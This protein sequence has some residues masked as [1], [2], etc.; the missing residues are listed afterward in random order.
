MNRPDIFVKTL[1]MSEQEIDLEKVKIK[2][3]WWKIASLWGSTLLLCYT[4]TNGYRNLE[5][6]IKRY[7]TYG[8]MIQKTDS[9]VKILLTEIRIK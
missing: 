4:I 3:T 1:A 9:V 6:K 7:D 5:E 8:V 2:V